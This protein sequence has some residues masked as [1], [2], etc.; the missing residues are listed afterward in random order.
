M[1]RFLPFLALGSF[2]MLTNPTSSQPA[3]SEALA[4]KTKTCFNCLGKGEAK[5]PEPTCRN[6]GKDCPAPCLKLSKGVWE[7]RDVPGHTD[8]DERWQRVKFGN[9][10]AYWS[11]KHIGEVPTL[12]ADGQFSSPQCTTCGGTAMVGCAKCKGRMLTTCEIC[13]GKKVVPESWSAFDH[14]KLKNRPQKFTMKDGRVIIARK[15][16]ISGKTVTLRTAT[17]EEKVSS[18]DIVSEA[19]QPTTR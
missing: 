12:S 14:P 2:L 11:S 5:C 18:D 3:A 1:N 7:K 15:T 17:G 6:G 13:A 8:P 16:M 19:S 9:K 4:E 10:S